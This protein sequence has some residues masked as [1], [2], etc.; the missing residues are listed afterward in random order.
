[1]KPFIYKRNNGNQQRFELLEFGFR[2][3][4]KKVDRANVAGLGNY[5]STEGGAIA[6]PRSGGIKGRAA[7]SAGN[8]DG[9]NRNARKQ[10]AVLGLL[11]MTHAPDRNACNQEDDAD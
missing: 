10:R 6:G 1:V 9:P 5:S 7:L 11:G 3:I 2:Q 4:K 8:S